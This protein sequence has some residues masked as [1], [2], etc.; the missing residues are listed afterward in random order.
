MIT[1]CICLVTLTSPAYTPAVFGRLHAPAKCSMCYFWVRVLAA[2]SCMPH[3]SC[4]EQAAQSMWKLF[5][6]H[7][8]MC[9]PYSLVHMPHNSC[10]QQAT[11]QNMW[12]AFLGWDCRVSCCQFTID[13]AICIVCIVFLCCV[14]RHVLL[15]YTLQHCGKQLPLSCNGRQQ[16]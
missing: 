1:P 2:V 3:I 8:S 7:P 15:D 14:S 13:W 6:L 12:E 5:V 4:L 10:L 16:D 11:A 9:R